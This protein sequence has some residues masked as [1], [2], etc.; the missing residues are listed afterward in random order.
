[1]LK[2][3]I[4]LFKVRHGRWKHLVF[5]CLF[6]STKIKNSKLPAPMCIYDVLL[7]SEVLESGNHYR[8]D[9]FSPPHPS[10][11]KKNT[12]TCGIHMTNNAFPKSCGHQNWPFLSFYSTLGSQMSTL[13]A[14]TNTIFSSLN[15]ILKFCL[16]G[17]FNRQDRIS[18]FYL[19]FH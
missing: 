7:R 13:K 11:K 5:T 9:A 14:L 18:F 12:W 2:F 15:K 19:H 3:V 16:E 1:M 6:C 10:V 4:I 17:F 8:V